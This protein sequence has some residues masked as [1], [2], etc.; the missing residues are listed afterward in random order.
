MRGCNACRLADAMQSPLVQA[1][2]HTCARLLQLYQGV[3]SPFHI[4]ARCTTG[5][6]CCCRGM[7]V[8]GALCLTPTQQF[9]RRCRLASTCNPRTDSTHGQ[10][11]ESDV[12]GC[13]GGPPLDDSFAAAQTEASYTAAMLLICLRSIRARRLLPLLQ[14]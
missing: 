11:M 8:L 3:D 14:C 4:E 12:T 6:M 10:Q 9:Y 7:D 13:S 2:P 1:Y 5:T